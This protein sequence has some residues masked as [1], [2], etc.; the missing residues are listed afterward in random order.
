M[1]ETMQT[2]YIYTL[3]D[4]RDGRV[5]YVGQSYDPKKRL[6]THKEKWDN[7]PKRLWLKELSSNGLRPVLDVLESVSDGSHRT[8]EAFW[9]KHYLDLGYDLLNLNRAMT[10]YPNVRNSKDPRPH[11]MNA[12]YER[13]G[14]NTPLADDDSDSHTL[15][16]RDGFDIISEFVLICG[17]NADCAVLLIYLMNECVKTIGKETPYIVYPN[18]EALVKKLGGNQY[19]WMT[20]LSNL[21]ELGLLYQLGAMAIIRYEE[22]EAMLRGQ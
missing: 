1:N 15:V 5:R 6:K 3:S 2:I 17:G 4:P 8:R 10:G 19:K 18:Y 21:Q 22:I 12:D 7:I 11:D 20:T 14:Y 13:M 9:I 16:Y